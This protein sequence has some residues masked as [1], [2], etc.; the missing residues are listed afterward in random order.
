MLDKLKECAIS[1]GKL[2]DVE[3][4]II[5]G[6]K[7]RIIK[8][9]LFFHKE[10]F[11]HLMGL[12]KLKDVYKIRGDKQ[13]IYN[14]I[15]NDEITYNDISKSEFFPEI[16]E[17]FKY[18]LLL[19]QILDSEDVLVK[20]NEFASKSHIKADYIIYKAIDDVIA[21]YFISYHSD[22]GKYF[23]T[24]FFA[25]NDRLY[26]HNRPYKILKKTKIKNGCIISEVTDKN[27]KEA[28]E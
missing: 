13:K 7:S 27:Y 3:Y 18:F 1:F 15:I 4:Y 9:I 14:D 5:A 20:H 2:I 21:H 24:T 23:G 10:H 22:N 6:K 17:R 8:P 12:H 19:E 16:T 11:Y 28:I 26:L 25:R